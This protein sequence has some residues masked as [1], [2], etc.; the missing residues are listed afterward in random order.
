[1][2]R[3]LHHA[4]V[5]ILSLSLTSIV[6]N[7]VVEESSN[8]GTLR[9]AAQTQ[10]IFF[11]AAVVAQ[12][13]KNDARYA[14]ALS[15]EFNIVTP[16]DEMKFGF[17]RPKRNEFNFSAA[18]S[19]VNFAFSHSMQ[20]RGHTLVWHQ[21][22]PQ[23][24]TERH[25]SPFEVA[26]ILKEHIQTVVGHYRGRI[27]AWDV[28]NEAID[29]NTKYRSSIWLD[30]LG[31][32]YVS[33]AFRWAHEA[34]PQAKLFY[35]DYGGEALGPKSDTIYDMIKTLKARSVPIDGIGL[36]S[37]L[38]ADHPPNFA[39]VLANLKRL[40]ALGLEIH[41]TELDVAITMPATAEKLQRQANIYRDY[42]KTCLAVPNCKAIVMWGA[43][44]RYSWV[45]RFVPGKGAP[46]LLD[47]E[48]RPKP[49]YYAALSELRSGIRFTTTL[50]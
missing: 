32:G 37:H 31:P 17:L 20:T 10:G 34:D 18:D 36:Q 27:Y 5:A 39:S 43:T 45:P 40:T 19:I 13:L 23:W 6:L 41:I 28:V 24:L 22:L 29:D 35:N 9:F 3:L 38:S 48:L 33:F 50:P 47:D 21:R 7:S 2:T 14:S 4:A 25:L 44:D 26:V 30:A 11:G 1:M 8:T 46:L 16:E 12:P 15:R 49:A 42:I